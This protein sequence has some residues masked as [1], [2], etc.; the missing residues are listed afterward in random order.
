MNIINLSDTD[1]EAKPGFPTKVFYRRIKA[2]SF[3]KKCLYKC[4]SKDVS[5][6]LILTEERQRRLDQQAPCYCL[7][8]YIEVVMGSDFKPAGGPVKSNS[9]SS[10]TL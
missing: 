10:N 4:L 1:R 6:F 3:A 5:I 8:W 9:G 2:V 7:G